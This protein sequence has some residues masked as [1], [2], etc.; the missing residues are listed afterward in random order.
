MA[1]WHTDRLDLSVQI[2]W[3]RQWARREMTY[4]CQRLDHRLVFLV[5]QQACHVRPL[6]PLS[7]P[8]P[9]RRPPSAVH[10]VAGSTTSP[11]FPKIARKKT[12]TTPRKRLYEAFF[13]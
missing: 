13:L 2:G 5:G 12:C 8:P 11:F 10:L 3:P 1:Q 6:L 4:G 9:W 7:L